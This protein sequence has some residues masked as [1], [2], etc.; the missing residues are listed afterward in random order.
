MSENIISYNNIMENVPSNIPFNKVFNTRTKRLNTLNTAKNSI[1]KGNNNPNDFINPKLL[2]NSKDKV[3]VENKR[4]V[5]RDIRYGRK[6]L[7]EQKV[8]KIQKQKEAL[9]KISNVMN[10]QKINAPKNVLSNFKFTYDNT[11]DKIIKNTTVPNDYGI[12]SQVFNYSR[13]TT[14]SILRDLVSNVNNNTKYASRI[15]I[16]NRELNKGTSTETI[17]TH[18][19][20]EIMNLIARMVQSD[21]AFNIKDAEIS[22][23]YYDIPVGEGAIKIPKWLEKKSK[24]VCIIKNDNIY[25]GH[26]AS[27][28]GM[29]NP[30]RRKYLNLP[31]GKKALEKEIQSFIIKTGLKNALTIHDFHKVSEV[32]NININIFGDFH[33]L[34]EETDNENASTIINLY[35]DSKAE[36]YHL[37]TNLNGFMGN[38]NGDYKY[39]LICKTRMKKETYNH[40]KCKG[41]SCNLCFQQFKTMDELISHK[42]CKSSIACSKCNLKCR[43]SKCLEIHQNGDGNRKGCQGKNWFYPCCLKEGYTVAQCWGRPEDKDIHKCDHAYCRICD[44]YKPRN[45]RCYIKPRELKDKWIDNL[46][47]FDFESRFD[48]EGRHYVNFIV[49]KERLSNER[50]IWRYKKGVDILQQFIDWCFTK[51]NTTFIAHNG[52]AYDTWLIHR[53]ICSVKGVRPSKLILAG[54]KIMYMKLGTISFI[55]SINHIAGALEKMPKTF[56]L[57]E[58]QFKK[59][60]YPYLFNTEENWEYEG[61]MP[62]IKYYN[63]SSMKP[64][65]RKEFMEWYEERIKIGY[66]YNHAKETEEYCISDVDILLES[67]NKYSLIGYDLTGIDPLSKTTLASWVM[68]TYLTKYYDFEKTP[69]AVLKK[70]EYDFIKRSFHGGRT[71]AIRTYRKWTDEELK[72]GKCGRYVDITSLYPSVQFY[73]DMPYGEPKWVKD[74]D[75]DILDYIKNNYGF[76]EVDIEMNKKEF[77]SP[78]V[79]HKDGK[80]TANVEDKEKSVFHSVELINA[81][82]LGKCNIKKIYKGLVFNKTNE[83]FKEFVSTFLRIKVEASGEPPFYRKVKMRKEWEEQHNIRYGFIPKPEKTENSGL[84]AIAKLIL[85]SLWGKFGQRPD[86]T[87]DKY[88]APNQL[89]EWYKLLR[90]AK[91]QVIEL[92]SDEISGDHLFISYVDKRDNNNTLNNTSIAIA[93]STTANA[94]MRLYKELIKLNDRVLYHDTDSIIY[95]YNPTEYNIQLGEYLGEWTCETNGKPIDEYVS[96]GAKSYAYKVD[97]KVKDTKMKGITLNYENGKKI[98]F[99]TMK[100]LIDGKVD[101]LI[102]TENIRFNKDKEDTSTLITTPIIKEVNLTM[103]KRINKGYY[104]YPKGYNGKMFN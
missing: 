6:R 74:I 76:Y 88:I 72:E 85:N 59:G 69:I 89:K 37:I 36:H 15:I 102:T 23:R 68:N 45:H 33:T 24:S 53:K 83:M 54:N 30:D 63:P 104:T 101:K 103:D 94:G 12:R 80:L 35:W 25:C 87:T 100:D 61:V 97:K 18:N 86:M 62:P 39:C 60:F 5:R 50:K 93:A 14:D 47:A 7:K 81:V 67:C 56:G 70:D 1:K 48:N 66:I 34:L 16:Y 22:I 77:I 78:L 27:I 99:D 43:G 98:C 28:L 65:K 21:E 10:N 82:E 41:L 90:M 46:V 11:P 26:I 79:S 2:W 40:H 52:K 84:R 58:T 31:K 8:I 57:D 3:F 96:P 73:D 91:S 20:D 71:E 51:K 17:E 19:P 4:G 55:D 44:E 32:Y 75:N 49:A 64:K 29:S 42:E 13:G 38:G 95:E 9:N 92:K